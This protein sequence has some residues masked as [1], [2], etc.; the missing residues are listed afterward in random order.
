MDLEKDVFD[1]F[2]DVH[3]DISQ[4]AGHECRSMV[5]DDLAMVNELAQVNKLRVL[6]MRVCYKVLHYQTVRN[7]AIITSISMRNFANLSI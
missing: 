3:E 5:E 4:K 2:R 6:Y 7:S 1:R